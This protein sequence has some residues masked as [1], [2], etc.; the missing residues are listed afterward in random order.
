M[1]RVSHSE[2]VAVLELSQLR[3]LVVESVAGRLLSNCPHL[4]EHVSCLQF[5]TV[6]GLSE[7]DV[8]LLAPHIVLLE[9]D[10]QASA[11]LD[12]AARMHR[13]WPGVGF[14]L[15]C[16]PGQMN[17]RLQG[18]AHGAD[19]CLVKP[20]VE[21][22]LVSVIDALARRLRMQVAPAG[23]CWVI[24][25]QRQMLGL[26]DGRFLELSRNEYLVL[27]CL[28]R[29]PD[30]TASRQSLAEGLGVNY[31][32]YDE[33]RLEAIVSRLRRKIAAFAGREAPI[34]ALRNKGYLFTGNLL[35]RH[36]VQG[37]A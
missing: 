23:D 32:T 21:V 20:M 37:R 11:E 16:E 17:L 12:L 10:G 22:E 24:D 34:R 29:A 8:A 2:N 15:A 7:I 36:R 1:K 3:L 25:S 19:Y 28:Q 27:Q 26:P 31:M 5:S 14:I 9:L 18:Y 4:H 6:E 30:Q 13:L 35:A 33:R